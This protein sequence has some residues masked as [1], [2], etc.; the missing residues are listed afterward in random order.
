[1]IDIAYVLAC[2][3]QWKEIDFTIYHKDIEDET[4]YGCWTKD[5][6]DDNLSSIDEKD[7]WI[8]KQILLLIS[9]KKLFIMDKE[10]MSAYEASCVRGFKDKKENWYC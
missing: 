1:M 6:K 7:K 5:G 10:Y 9:E 2:I 8:V 3:K 4:Y